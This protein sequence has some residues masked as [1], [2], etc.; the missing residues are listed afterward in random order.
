MRTDKDPTLPAE[1]PPLSPRAG[2]RHRRDRHRP[3]LSSDQGS[4]T[5]WTAALISL[6]CLLA[7]TTMTASGIRA[8]RHQAQLAADMA[9]LTA[10]TR[11]TRGSSAPCPHARQAALRA[12]ARLTACTL[13]PAPA[14]PGTI[15]EV[16]VTLPLRVPRWLPSLAIP[17]TARAGP[18]PT[19]A[20]PALPQPEPNPSPPQPEPAPPLP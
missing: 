4:A 12:G 3:G 6:I 13:T 19:T 9:A 17:A 2:A 5:I 7:I 8:A 15:A 18:T 20:G 14:V 1:S 16:T 11:H 10:A